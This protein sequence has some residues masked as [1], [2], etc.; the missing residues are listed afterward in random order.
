MSDKKYT[1]TIYSNKLSQGSGTHVWVEISDG[2]FAGTIKYSYGPI[3]DADGNIF[4]G[5]SGT[6]DA[7]LS[8]V[9][10]SDERGAISSSYTGTISKAQYLAAITKGEQL[11]LDPPKYEV[12]ELGGDNCVE[13]TSKI[14]EAAGIDIA[15]GYVMPD[16]LAE[17]LDWMKTM[18]DD[19]FINQE[20]YKAYKEFDYADSLSKDPDDA[21]AFGKA[22]VSDKLAEADSQVYFNN[23]AKLEAGLVIKELTNYKDLISKVLGTNGDTS[24][25]SIDQLVLGKFQQAATQRYG[26]PLVVDLDRDNQIETTSADGS[27]LFD[28]SGNGQAVG[29]GWVNAEDGLLV[30]DVDGS[31]TIDS[32]R[33]L[34]GDNTIKSDGTKAK[35]GFDALSDLDSNSDG[36][37]NEQDSAFSE[38]KVWQDADQDGVT[39]QGELLSLADAG[40]SSIDLNAKTVNQSV[41]GGILRKTST[42]TN[43]DGTTTAVGAMDFAENK[44]YS[45]FE[46]V[47]ETSQ[48]LQN[49][50]NVAGQGALRSLH[51]S[52][53]LS[54]DLKELLTGLYSG[55]TLVTDSAIHEVLLEWAR[56]SQNFETSLDILDGVTL[57]D[58]TQINV[59]ISDRVRTVIEKTA[60]L[61][62]LNGSRILEYNIRDNG[63]TY[64]INA[65]TGTETFW[66]TR[67]VAKG[68]TTT[69]GDWFFHRLAD[70]ARATNISQGYASAFNS[71]KESIETSH[72]VKEVYPVLL[73]NLSFELDDAGEVA[74][75]FDGINDAIVDKIKVDPISGLSFF[76][77]VI[78]AQ[79]QTFL[80]DGWDK[81][82]IL[83]DD[84]FDSI[85]ARLVESIKV[86]VITGL[87][88]V[89]KIST[90]ANGLLLE[91]GWDN[92][93]IFND[94]IFDFIND[95]LI[96]SV[97]LDIGTGFQEI[98][99]ISTIAN[100][101]LLESGWDKKDFL[102]K[103]LSQ[104][105]SCEILIIHHIYRK[106]A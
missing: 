80:R 48:E 81:K 70:N 98:N 91:S 85:N 69:T 22:M 17:K 90:V 65:K 73:E 25:M 44:F 78:K 29:T 14:L 31:G 89:N 77:R 4:F 13:V 9:S 67:T 61:E 96:E 39:D 21:L 30:R 43:T 38:V 104:K 92:K 95:H 41:A 72:F 20:K 24:Q 12:F 100:G 7:K 3:K 79:D 87:Q 32:G 57:D 52:A 55:E 33:E 105:T 75:N 84:L 74:L 6:F 19:I 66:D 26:D 27:V 58:G 93:E 62:A 23:L 82:E 56:T 18:G 60:V 16:S 35:D 83:N 50:I 5:K 106:I 49:S 97:K 11:R 59:G 2:T 68:G 86:D 1:F 94:D 46:D 71:I 28:H 34:F 36:V 102:E 10:D 8:G 101:L 88:E 45:K 99:E 51:E 64:T 42:A 40:I 47:L 37:F 63:S 15:L 76:D 53:S 103:D 54:P